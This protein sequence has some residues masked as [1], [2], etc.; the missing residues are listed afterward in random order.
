M[1]QQKGTGVAVVWWWFFASKS[2]DMAVDFDW[3]MFALRLTANWA[4]CESEFHA[5]VF[6]LWQREYRE[7]IALRVKE[8]SGL[9][10][11]NSAIHKA[12]GSLVTGHSQNVASR[13]PRNPIFVSIGMTLLW[14][15]LTWLFL[16]IGHI[17]E[18]I[19]VVTEIR[20]WKKLV[21]VTDL[22]Q[23]RKNVSPWIQF[24]LPH[25]SRVPNVIFSIMSLRLTSG[26]ELIGGFPMWAPL[27]PYQTCSTWT[28]L[29]RFSWHSTEMHSCLLHLQ[30]LG[31]FGQI[32]D[33]PFP[34]LEI[35]K[36][37]D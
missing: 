2:C 6:E 5:T 4:D 11:G 35:Y 26:R 15:R 23:S 18:Y 27:G 36:L 25:C 17:W 10:K 34:R 22:D 9:T 3:L 20:T 28:S 14:L 12:A 19:I 33:W 1:N 24:S 37:S 13:N 31:T 7:N 21:S 29:S 16:H 30:F 8:L 32:I